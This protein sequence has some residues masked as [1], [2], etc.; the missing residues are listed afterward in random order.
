MI[1]GIKLEARRWCHTFTQ[2]PL[3]RTREIEIERK[4]E[5]KNSIYGED[6]RSFVVSSIDF[7]LN[8]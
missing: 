5:R 3:G 1:I 4:K 2:A 6:R 7:I 8:D